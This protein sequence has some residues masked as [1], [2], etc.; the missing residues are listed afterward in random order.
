MEQLKNIYIIKGLCHNA[1]T[2]K[3]PVTR[4]ALMGLVVQRVW[5]PAP[6]VTR[7]VWGPTVVQ[8]V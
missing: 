8:W 5:G 7:W 4:G 6:A 1:I 2:T 3:Q